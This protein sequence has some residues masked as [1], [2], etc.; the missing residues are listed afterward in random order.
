[1][2]EKRGEKFESQKKKKRKMKR[3][4]MMVFAPRFRSENI[5]NESNKFNS[6]GTTIY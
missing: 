2:G 3:R 6:K 1:M 4:N 5:G